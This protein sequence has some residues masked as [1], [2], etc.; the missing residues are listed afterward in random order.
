MLY[1]I[2]CSNGTMIDDLHIRVDR[3][4]DGAK[5]VKCYL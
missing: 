3:V 1:D 2:Y 5:Q 4:D